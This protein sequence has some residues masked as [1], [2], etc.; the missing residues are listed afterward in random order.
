MTL[1]PIF[2]PFWVDPPGDVPAP[3]GEAS[4]CNPRYLTQADLLALLER[5]QAPHYID[6]IKAQGPGYEMYQAFAKVFERASLA[7]G[8]LECD[9]FI[10]TAGGGETSTATVTFTR[11]NAAAGVVV[12]K[13]GTIVVTSKGGHQYVLPQDLT[14]TG[15]SAGPALVRAIAQGFEYD[16]PGPKTTATGA[17]LEGEIDTIE[18]PLQDPAYGDPTVVVAQTTDGV[19]GM[20]AMLDALG[21]DRGIRR[22]DGEADGPYRER[23]RALPDTV[24][25][26]AIKRLVTRLLSPYTDAPYEFIETF[27][28]KYQTCWDAP[29]TPIAANPDYDPNLFAYDDPRTDTCLLYTSPSP[30]DGATSR[31]PSSA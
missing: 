9:V 29:S 17:V 14:L 31:M 3:P 19:G 11:P 8:R 2:L 28:I 13:A 1:R 27:D 25:P 10:L 22:Q 21:E 16:Q 12:L 15:T 23:I 20:P 5:V 4:L 30:R 26:D 7:V 6:P 18:L 24:S